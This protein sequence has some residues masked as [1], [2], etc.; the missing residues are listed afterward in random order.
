MKTLEYKYKEKYTAKELD[1]VVLWLHS[2]GWRMR[3]GHLVHP[4]MHFSWHWQDAE[5]LQKEAHAG[6][7]LAQFLLEVK[8][9]Q[10]ART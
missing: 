2:N 7:K 4:G 8:P 3:H 10:K 6:D 5:R 1:E 9:K